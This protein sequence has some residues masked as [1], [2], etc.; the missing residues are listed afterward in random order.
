MTNL[1]A[2]ASDA[3]ATE[4]EIS[5]CAGIGSATSIVN[6][7]SNDILIYGNHTKPAISDG[8]AAAGDNTTLA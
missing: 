4:S 1:I 8:G 2:V 6:S 5:E 3:V 7:S